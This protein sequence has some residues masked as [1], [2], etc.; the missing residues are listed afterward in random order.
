MRDKLYSEVW[1]FF[2][3]KSGK[4]YYERDDD[5]S[6]LRCIV[7]SN[8]TEFSSWSCSSLICV[9]WFVEQILKL[10][11]KVTKVDDENEAKRRFKELINDP[12]MFYNDKEI[13]ANE[14]DANAHKVCSTVKDAEKYC[15]H[16][17]AAME[18][19]F[20]H[21]KQVTFTTWIHYFLTV[22]I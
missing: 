5:G 19:W 10:A 14:S 17:T 8:L 15:P 22:K 16:R 11:T 6:E 1:T 9:D 2:T 4:I 18:N 12:K 21:T 3:T 7:F 20:E 13:P